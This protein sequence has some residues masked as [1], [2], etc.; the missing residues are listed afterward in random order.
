MK[1]ND[2]DDDIDMKSSSSLRTQST[3]Q[4]SFI[5][6]DDFDSYDNG[7]DNYEY[8]EQDENKKDFAVVFSAAASSAKMAEYT[9][10]N[11]SSSSS[12]SSSSPSLSSS[13]SS[14][15]SNENRQPSARDQPRQF[16]PKQTKRVTQVPTPSSSS[17]SMNQS[18]LVSTIHKQ[19]RRSSLKTSSLS[20]SNNNQSSRS[21][22]FN[23]RVYVKLIP[24]YSNIS[25][26]KGNNKEDSIAKKIWYQP[27]EY[28]S[29]EQ[30][31]VA[32][33]HAVQETK[34]IGSKYCI[35][36]LERYLNLQKLQDVRWKAM[37]TV[38]DEQD[39]QYRQGSAFDCDRLS[40]VYRDCTQ[41]ARLEAIER[42][43]Q[44]E[45]SIE[46]YTR[47]MRQIFGT[48]GFLS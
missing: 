28:H 36:G 6:C 35:R 37:D 39:L 45:I 7:E 16:Q 44:D 11:A 33:I 41:R 3:F 24:K 22:Q 42:A 30:R 20:R 25:S 38:L 27:E 13:S 19:P 18:K 48:R 43:K 17:R 9:K 21:I 46:K 34:I 4:E 12:Q 14:S 23:E 32:L 8:N 1:E 26:K 31:S 2:D 29:I 5:A 40:R 10:T 47:K 15:S